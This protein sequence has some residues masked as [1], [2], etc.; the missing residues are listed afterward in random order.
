MSSLPGSV[1]G[2]PGTVDGKAGG[3]ASFAASAAHASS[4]TGVFF[5]L[6][7][8]HQS[9]PL[10]DV[11]G[12]AVGVDRMGGLEREASLDC[13]PVMPLVDDGHLLISASSGK[14]EFSANTRHK[15]SEA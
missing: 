11:G 12:F 13:A 1:D 2:K 10:V 14:R 15:V 7:A 3:M 8:A 5:G 4:F 9:S 6:G